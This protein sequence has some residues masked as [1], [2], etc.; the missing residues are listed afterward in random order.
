MRRSSAWFIVLLCSVV[1]IFSAVA[2]KPTRAN[3]DGYLIRPEPAFSWKLK[4][5]QSTEAGTVYL[6]HL[7]SQTWHGITWEHQIQVYHPKGAAPQSR[8]L[9]MITGGSGNAGDGK[10]DLSRAGLNLEIAKR[11]QAPFA[12]LTHVPNQPLLG[13]KKEDALIAETFVRFLETKDETWPLLLPMTKSALKAMDALQQFAQQEWKSPVKQFILTGGS[14]RGW[15]SWLAGASGD[16]RIMAIAPLVIDT[17]NM[18]AQLPH[19]VE[20]L[21]GY[22]EMIGD[23]TGRKLVPMPNTPEAKKLWSMVDPWIYRDRLQMPK[24]IVNGNNDPYWSTDALNLYWNDLKGD[25]WV[26]YVPNAGHDL[27]Q[28]QR[29]GLDQARHVIN[30]LAAFARHQIHDR[31]MPK[32]QWKH[33]DVNGNLR[34]TVDCQ[35][36]PAGGRLWVAHAPTRDFRQAKWVEH[37]AT[38][39][40]GK[41]VGEVKPPADGF[42]AFYGETDYAFDDL[43][44]HL[45]TQLRVAG[46]STTKKGQ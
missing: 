30:G 9:L 1:A 4:D 14:K 23:Y 42:L 39:K 37:P 11:L 16:T 6:L 22:S 35:P 15:T 25:K 19:Q 44:Y 10:L 43:T 38:C 12:V 27:R 46:N 40:D 18:Q 3:L 17:L 36:P 24:L 29:L 26:I 32:L 21:G 31:P 33:E 2:T 8:L 20:T 7:V 28:K 45:S 13:D 5:Q 34:L 41:L